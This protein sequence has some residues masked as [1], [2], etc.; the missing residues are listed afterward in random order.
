MF[1][2]HGAHRLSLISHMSPTL[3]RRFYYYDASRHTGRRRERM[4][5]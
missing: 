2:T 5:D 4:G 1:L 3:A